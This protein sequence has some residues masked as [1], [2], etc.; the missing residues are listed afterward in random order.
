MEKQNN[1]NK[2]KEKPINEASDVLYYK[3]N[4]HDFEVNEGPKT[5]NCFP[6]ELNPYKIL[7]L[8]K[9]AKDFEIEL[10]FKSRNM[11]SIW[12]FKWT[13]FIGIL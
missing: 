13:I 12:N 4:D 2:E 7:N 10:K 6:V 11:F 9:N 8:K 5:E 1:G 3:W